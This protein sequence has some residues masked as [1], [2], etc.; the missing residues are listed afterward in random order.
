VGQQVA[1]GVTTRPEATAYAERQLTELLPDGPATPTHR[2]WTV[3]V[4][5]GPSVGSLWLR[6]P[7]SHERGS[8]YVFDVDIAPSHRGRGLGRATMLAA[9]SA[10]R[11]AGASALSLNVFGHNTA[12][13]GLYDALGYTVTR[14][15]LSRRLRRRTPVSAQLTALSAVRLTE[16]PPVRGVELRR[17][18][19]QEYAGA[20]PSLDRA[21]S[22][23]L[24]RLL[25]DGPATDG[26]RVWVVLDADGAAV[27]TAWM[28]LQHRQDGAHALVRQVEVRPELR[29]RGHG[30]SAVLALQ[31]VAQ[32]LGVVTLTVEVDDPVARA[33]F[34]SAGLE[35]TAQSMTKAL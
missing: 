20:R 6:L 18:T 15:T 17:M 13:L 9:E 8:A 10:A 19:E 34:V 30:R 3:H 33:T 12:A 27:G 16:L 26:Q 5:D 32:Q 14:S 35:V 24:D 2:I 11:A 29:R 21:A 1:A 4:G 28:S 7:P 31:H 25:P 22:G 23:R